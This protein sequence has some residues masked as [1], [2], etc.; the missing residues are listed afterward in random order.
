MKLE[1]TF[2][3]AS[4]ISDCTKVVLLSDGPSRRVK[5]R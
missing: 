1:V 3:D 2:W 5:L 4:A